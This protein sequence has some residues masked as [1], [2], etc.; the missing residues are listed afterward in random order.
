MK[1]RGKGGSIVNVSSIAA[2]HA[3]PNYSVYASTKG[4]VQALT[5]TMAHEFGPYQVYIFK[6]F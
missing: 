6:L 2:L 4:A 3:I 1:R 5:I